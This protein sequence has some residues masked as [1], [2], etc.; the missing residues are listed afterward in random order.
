MAGISVV[1]HFSSRRIFIPLENAVSIHANI[2]P[3][4]LPWACRPRSSTDYDKFRFLASAS[5]FS[6]PTWSTGGGTP[7]WQHKLTNTFVPAATFSTT[8]LAFSLRLPPSVL[9]EFSGG[10][11]GCSSDAFT[12]K[13]A[14]GVKTFPFGF[15]WV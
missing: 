2:P 8:F 14:V 3:Q 13:P 10:A 5:S 11:H 7:S 12:T 9:E 4:Q 1:I 6:R 15:R